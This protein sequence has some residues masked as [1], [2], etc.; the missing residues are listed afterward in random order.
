MYFPVRRELKLSTKT[1]RW[2]YSYV[3]MYFPVRRELKPKSHFWV[4][5]FLIVQMYFPVRRELKLGNFVIGRA[6]GIRS[7]VL[8]RS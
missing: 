7:D 2:G 8:S 4:T 1:T 6:N 5:P 3:Q